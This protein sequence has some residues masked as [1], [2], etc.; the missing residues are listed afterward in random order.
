MTAA[1][2][3]DGVMDEACWSS[4][5]PVTNFTQVLPVT[6]APHSVRTELRFLVTKDSL[7]IGIRCFDSTPR[8][9]IARKMLRDAELNGDDLVR[10]SFDTFGCGRDGY[11]FEVNPNVPVDTARRPLQ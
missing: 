2:T 5:V 11:V 9:I 3:L 6:G 4:A 7:F 10:I 1:P 8:G